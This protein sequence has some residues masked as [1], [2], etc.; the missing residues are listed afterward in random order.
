MGLTDEPANNEVVDKFRQTLNE[1]STKNLADRL[2]KFEHNDDPREA[3]NPNVGIRIRRID[4]AKSIAR[5]R[6]PVTQE[7]ADHNSNVSGV[8][9]PERFQRLW[10][11]QS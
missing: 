2:V 8:G 10:G 3:P 1:I 11:G 5:G 7:C 4:L 9:H 6:V